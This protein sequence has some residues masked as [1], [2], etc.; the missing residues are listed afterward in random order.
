MITALYAIKETSS[1]MLNSLV[2]DNLWRGTEISLKQPVIHSSER[3]SAES[4]ESKQPLK[5]LG[6]LHFVE[7]GQKF[8]SFILLLFSNQNA[9]GSKY[10]GL[11]SG[12]H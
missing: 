4:A 12:L 8:Y 10:Q 11:D 6:A 7:P 9:N 1:R 3:A 2:L 5:L